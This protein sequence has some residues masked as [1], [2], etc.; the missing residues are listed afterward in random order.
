MHLQTSSRTRFHMYRQKHTQITTGQSSSAKA[1]SSM[2]LVRLK[3]QA[4]APTDRYNENLQS[5]T[6]TTLGP[7]IS[8][9]KIC[10]LL[11]FS[12]I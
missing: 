6:R 2:R 8:R 7:E 1:G 12:V 5:R 9:K 11:K 3:P 10:S 4:R